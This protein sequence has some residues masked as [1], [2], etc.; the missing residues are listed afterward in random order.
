[1]NALTLA[2]AWRNRLLCFTLGRSGL[3]PGRLF[4]LLLSLCR[5]RSASP[6]PGFVE[7]LEELELLD[8]EESSSSLEVSCRV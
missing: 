8:K 5:S 2:P 7:E 1:M 3:F 4:P 6:G